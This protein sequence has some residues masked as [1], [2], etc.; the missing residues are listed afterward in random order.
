MC[1]RDRVD[2]SGNVI[3]DYGIETGFIAQEVLK[4]EDL[5]YTVDGLIEQSGNLIIPSDQSLRLVY[6]D[7]FVYGIQ[8]IKELH[9][10]QEKQIVDISL[11]KVDVESLKSENDDLKTKI[12]NLETQLESVLKRLSILENN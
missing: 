11:N 4:I 1:I 7:I 12:T 5:K 3:E 9:F 6:N 10:Q 8:G 2:S